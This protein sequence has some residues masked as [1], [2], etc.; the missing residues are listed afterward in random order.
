MQT[1]GRTDARNWPV[2]FEEEICVPWQKPKRNEHMNTR[3]IFVQNLESWY[4][5][6]NASI[7]KLERYVKKL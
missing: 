3:L 1:D 6:T 5:E 4:K 2:G 7:E